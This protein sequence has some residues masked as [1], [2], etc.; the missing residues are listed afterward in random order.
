[1]TYNIIVNALSSWLHDDRRSVL[2]RQ[3]R[4]FSLAV[5]LNLP[6]VLP[7]FNMTQHASDHRTT[8]ACCCYVINVI[9]YCYE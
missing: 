6:K 7:P 9:C 5:A 1:M 2:L 4:G 8:T 3:V